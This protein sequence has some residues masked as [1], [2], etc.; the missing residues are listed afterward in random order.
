[1][2]SSVYEH[3]TRKPSRSPQ[4]SCPPWAS[5]PISGAGRSRTF[6]LQQRRVTLRVRKANSGGRT[7]TDDKQVMGLS[8]CQLRHPAIIMM[9]LNR[10]HPE[11]DVCKKSPWKS[12]VSASVWTRTRNR[13]LRRQVLKPIELRVTMAVRQTTYYSILWERGA[14]IFVSMSL[15]F[16]TPFL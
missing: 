15:R 8:R 4:R 14:S 7:R 16:A 11:E 9:S 13:L 3:R 1:M 5:H 12:S 6:S 2:F 10:P